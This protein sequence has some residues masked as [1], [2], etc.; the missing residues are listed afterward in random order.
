MDKFVVVIP[1]YEPDEDFVSYAEELICA[2]DDL[3]V[4]DDGSGKDYDRVFD[5]IS[6]LP[7]TTVIRYPGN[8]GKGFALKTAFSHCAENFDDDDIIVTADCDGQHKIKDVYKIYEATKKHKDKMVLGSRDFTGK[9]VP[10]RS[11]AGNKQMRILLRLF[12]GIKIYDSQTGL[13][14]HSIAFT[15]KLLKVRGKKF[16]YETNTLIYCKRRHLPVIEIFIDTVYPENEK[17]H[18]THFRAFKDSMRVVGIIIANMYTYLTS[19]AMS[20]VIDLGLFYFLAYVVLPEKT[21]INSL[22][23]TVAPRVVS[24]IFNFVFNYRHVF[25]GMSKK[26]FFRYYVLWFSRLAAS[27]GVLYLFG[28]LLG[29]NFMAIKIISEALFL[30]LTYKIQMDWVFK[31]ER[32]NAFYRPIAR[33]AKKLYRAF[34]GNKYRTDVYPTSEPKIYVCRHLDMHGVKTALCS[35]DFDV[36]VMALNTFFDKKTAYKQFKDYTFS[37]RVGKKPKKHSVKA[38]LAAK[39]TVAL[40]KSLRAVPVYRNSGLALETFKKGMEYLKNGESLI[41]FP[42]VDYT[43]NYGTVS[44]IYDGFLYFGQLYKRT[45]GKDVQFV[46]LVIDDEHKKILQRD[47]ITASDFRRE[48]QDKKQQIIAAKNSL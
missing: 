38:K 11:R 41:V 6:A 3:V 23:I 33:L 39:G 20:A 15:K 8:K 7:K 14:G 4:V 2:V 37:E 34:S 40:V 30:I 46:P 43:A 13:R 26:S 24:S 36:H 45:Y 47:P 18:K 28:N 1:A 44:D 12:Y 48:A 10:K 35:L 16:E 29:L 31:E 19:S 9:N 22:L 25:Y 42:D 17:D 21:A 5:K 32:K 27:Y